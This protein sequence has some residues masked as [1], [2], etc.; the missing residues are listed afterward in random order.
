MGGDNVGRMQICPTGCAVRA[1]AMAAG[2]VLFQLSSGAWTGRRAAGNLF[3]AIMK[4]SDENHR[5]SRHLQVK[6]RLEG[7]TPQNI[8]SVTHRLS[9][10]SWFVF[11]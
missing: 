6:P 5:V 2:V 3:E 10:R 8:I 7:G 4:C 9:K 1:C 11:L